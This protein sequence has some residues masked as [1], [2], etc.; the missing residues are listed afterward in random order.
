MAL[1][2]I[3]VF[4]LVQL[5]VNIL[6]HK[7]KNERFAYI[8]VS[9]APIIF[10][11]LMMLFPIIFIWIIDLLQS[12]KSFPNEGCGNVFF[13]VLLFLWIIGCPLAY[14]LQ[15]LLNRNMHDL[16]ALLIKYEKNN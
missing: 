1:L 13:G 14:L 15:V 3:P 11:L 5:V 7:A 9:L 10:T 16:R 8:F 4:L 12:S 2:A 6:V